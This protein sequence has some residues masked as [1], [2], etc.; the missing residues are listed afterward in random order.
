MENM[1]IIDV[2]Y[3][4]SDLFWH[5]HIIALCQSVCLSNVPLS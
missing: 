1:E 2:N 5:K 4:I 3:R